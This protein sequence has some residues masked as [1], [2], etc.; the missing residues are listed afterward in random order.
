MRIA[1]SIADNIQ[2]ARLPSAARLDDNASIRRSPVVLIAKRIE[3]LEPLRLCLLGSH[4][5]GLI[6]IGRNRLYSGLYSRLNS[7]L[8]SRLHSGLTRYES[9]SWRILGRSGRNRLG[10]YI[11]VILK[12]C[13]NAATKRI[14][15][16]AVRRTKRCGRRR[17]FG[18]LPRH[19][20]FAN[21]V[22]LF[23]CRNQNVVI[24]AAFEHLQQRLSHAQISDLHEWQ[25]QTTQITGDV[26]LQ[27]HLT[28]EQSHHLPEGL[29]LRRK[30]QGSAIER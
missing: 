19:H 10:L 14:L 25:A 30:A 8:Y 26:N 6:G 13:F 29:V 27:T 11:G 22:R 18:R 24:V 15:E 16:R 3:G 9:L 28:L 23:W 20:Q 5:D 17:H 1:V 12:G 21:T 7:G 2:Y 4:A